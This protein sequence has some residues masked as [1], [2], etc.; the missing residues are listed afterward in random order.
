MHLSSCRYI[1]ATLCNT[2]TA[3]IGDSHWLCPP[4][5]EEDED[6]YIVRHY[7]LDRKELPMNGT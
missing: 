6:R 3:R 7:T 1:S 4:V 2:N 5:H